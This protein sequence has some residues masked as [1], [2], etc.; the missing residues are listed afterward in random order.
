MRLRKAVS[1]AVTAAMVF[2]LAACGS[3]G[4]NTEESAAVNTGQTA[5]ESVQAEKT[6]DGIFDE[7]GISK[8]GEF[9]I[10][11]EPITLSIFVGQQAGVVDITK[12]SIFK[13]VSELT[14][15]NFDFIVAPQ[16]GA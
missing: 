6:Y 8:P 10:S 1:L 15:I 12:H 3:G 7:N 11:K 13:E 14:N 5:N 9:P 16:E 4:G 2:S